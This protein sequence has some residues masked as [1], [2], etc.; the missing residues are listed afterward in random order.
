MDMNPKDSSNN[1]GPG[2][3]GEKKPKW[4]LTVAVALAAALLAFM[5]SNMI[6]GSKYKEK[7]FSDFLDAKLAG[8]LAEVQLRADRI[9]YL[10]HGGGVHA[11]AGEQLGEDHGGEIG[12]DEGGQAGTGLGPGGTHAVS[13]YNFLHV[14]QP[15]FLHCSKME[16][17][18]MPPPMHMVTMA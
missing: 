18:P 2:A 1:K 8:E 16:A 15:S 17:K 3:P 5:V 4:L 13:D 6:N 9:L 12:G 7:T 11:G 10:I 14:H